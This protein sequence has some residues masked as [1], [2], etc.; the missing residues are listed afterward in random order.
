MGTLTLP[1]SGPVFLD[2]SGVIYSVERIPAYSDSL[3]PMWRQAQAGQFGIVSSD[4]VI[5]ETPV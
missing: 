1:P 3:K 4:L 2:A 5:L